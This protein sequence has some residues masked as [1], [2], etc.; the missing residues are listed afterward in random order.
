MSL[1]ADT[2]R[3]IAKELT[4]F[5]ASPMAYLFLAAFVTLS[6]FIFF[7]VEGFF[8]RNIADVRPLFEWMPILL[9]FLS[10]ALTMR[11]W[12]EEKRMG[13][14]E[15]VLTQPSGIWRFVLAKFLACLVLLFIALVLSFPIVIS[16][17]AISD[18]DWGPV[19]S[20]YFATFLL[21]AAYISIGLCISARSDNQIVSL[22]LSVLVCGLLYLIGS[23]LMTGLFNTAIGD[24]LRLIGSGSHFESITRGIID[25]R[26]FYYYL[27][28]IGVGLMLNVYVLE[29]S[30]WAKNAHQKRHFACHLLTALV[31]INLLF[32]NVWLRQINYLRYDT[33][34]GKIYSL[35]DSTKQIL[36]QLQEPLLIRGYFSAQT[37]PLLAPLVPQIIDLIEEY[38]VA[39]N[40]LVKVEIID[41]ASDPA[42]EDEANNKYSIR[43]TPFQ[44]S[45]RYQT[46]VVNSYFDVLLQYGDEYKNLSFRDLIEIQQKRETEI[47]VLL[48]NPEYDMSNAI[49]KIIETYQS[50]GDLFSRAK[51][52]QFTLYVS[53]DDKL[54]DELKSFKKEVISQVN[55]MVS[56]SGDK[57][58]FQV[59]DPAANGGAVAQQIAQDY[60]FKPMVLS[61]SDQRQFFFYMLLSEGTRGVVVPLG[62]LQAGDFEQSFKSSIKRLSSGYTKTVGLFS[63]VQTPPPGLPLNQGSQNAY[64]TISNALSEDMNMQE[65][66]L[67]TGQVNGDVDLLVLLGANNLSEEE[68][69]ALDQYLM[70]GGSVIIATSPYHAELTNTT[71]DL[72]KETGS[73]VSWLSTMGLSF[74]E[75]VVMDEQSAPFPVPVVRNV[76]GFEFQQFQLLQYPYFSEV[77]GDGLNSNDN[78]TAALQRV[79]MTWA[80][81]IIVSETLSSS[82]QVVSLMKSSSKAWQSNNTNVVPRLTADGKTH[83]EQPQNTQQ[84]TLGLSVQG[85]F[86]SWFKDKTVPQSLSNSSQSLAFLNVINRSPESAKIILFSSGEFVKDQI[87]QLIGSAN[88]SNFR[89]NISLLKNAVDVSLEGGG[90]QDIRAR[91]N[92]NRT[93]PKM[94]LSTQQ[95]IE[96]GNY[97]IALF[98]LVMIALLYQMM[99]KRRIRHYMLALADK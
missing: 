70:R 34:E 9:I 56:D 26:D 61:L 72:K 38:E 93:L 49:N 27:S 77:R 71:I 84:F 16:V 19:Y 5:F 54:P 8:T 29:K 21:G 58:S 47:D 31:I 10:S 76:G 4:I 11:L 44:V 33:T 94:E 3:I 62:D 69:F 2:K 48:R 40:G 45:D 35:S 59:I 95:W 74:G 63:K 50:A 79:V 1:N 86:D 90:L 32:A 99:Y 12:S 60:D 13:T 73:L 92:F 30:R 23:P 65:V 20:G 82:H 75:G 15:H 14:L 91:G 81:P 66:N 41:P 68:I 55:Q 96:Y 7:W 80:S 24:I 6:L 42:L 78:I 64:R 57:L 25:V 85:R 17:S 83:F 89:D 37:H 43:P 18:I 67:A 51:N 98:I 22:I 97:A 36:K 87:M 39:G 52:M 53:A 88:R 28:L 46:S